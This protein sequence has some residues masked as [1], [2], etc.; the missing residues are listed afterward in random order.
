MF[1]LDASLAPNFQ[2]FIYDPHNQVICFI[3]FTQLSPFLRTIQLPFVVISTAVCNATQTITLQ[4][5]TKSCIFSSIVQSY[6]IQQKGIFRR[7][8][9][10][11]YYVAIWRDIDWQY[12]RHRWIFLL[13]LQNI[14]IMTVTYELLSYLV[15]R[16][17]YFC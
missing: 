11:Q 13:I 2:G 10:C 14:V 12:Q 3:L 8:S 9:N 1:L 4:L 7:Y 15:R 5:L 16:N 6:V 17:G